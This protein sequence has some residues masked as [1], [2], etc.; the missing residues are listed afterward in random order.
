MWL[1]YFVSRIRVCP[2][3]SSRARQATPLTGKNNPPRSTFPIACP[4]RKVRIDDDQE[5]GT[6]RDGC[7]L[8]Y[9]LHVRVQC[10]Y[11][12]TDF[13]KDRLKISKL[14]RESQIKTRMKL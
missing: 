11:I 9:D 13:R 2:L 7:W 6:E 12:M 14:P 4:C 10:T 3:R 8:Q 5:H 1:Y